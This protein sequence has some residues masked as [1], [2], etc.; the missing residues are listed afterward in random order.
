M[1]SEYKSTD[2]EV[3]LQQGYAMHTRLDLWICF[4]SLHS[5]CPEDFGYNYRNCFGDECCHVH[6]CESH[7][8]Q[9][10]LFDVYL[11]GFSAYSI[12]YQWVLI[13]LN[14][15]LVNVLHAVWIYFHNLQEQLDQVDKSFRWGQPPIIFVFR[16]F[17]SK[18]KHMGSKTATWSVSDESGCENSRH[19]FKSWKTLK[20]KVHS[21][22]R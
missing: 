2:P 10:Q 16:A 4:G 19:V 6:P 17:I 20:T 7:E 1:T 22:F 18:T 14:V 8:Q 5:D 13:G 3:H 15:Y 21:W 12:Y 11:H 9:R